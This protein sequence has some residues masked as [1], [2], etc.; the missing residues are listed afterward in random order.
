MTGQG[1]T[2]RPELRLRPEEG[3]LALTMVVVMSLVLAMALDDPAW[4]NGK[5][6]LTDGL[7]WC[8][9]LGTLVGFVGPKVGWGRWTTHLVG[10][11]LAALIIP[12]IAGLAVSPPG[13]SIG[14]AFQEAASGSVQAYLDIAWLGRRFTD[15]EV[16]YILVLGMV[17]WATAQF[18]AYAVFGHGRPLSGVVVSGLVLLGNMALT[19]NNELPYLVVYAGASLLLL[20]EMHVFEERST[21]IRRQIGDPGSI[22]ALYLRGGAVF[23]AVALFGSLMLTDRAA[24]A[25]LA[26][27]WHGLDT[28][29]VDVGRTIQAWL[30]LGGDA[31]SFGSVTFGS[32]AVIGNRWFIGDGIAFTATV[33]STVPK[34]VYWRAASYDSYQ[35]NGWQQASGDTTEVE[36]GQPLLA[37]TPEDPVTELTDPAQVEIRT[38]AYADRT[39]LSPGTP[40]AVSSSA[41]VLL[42]DPGL[43][44]ARVELPGGVT[45][46]TVDA[47]ILRMTDTNVISDHL[48]EAASQDYPQDIVDEYT[49]VPPG[50]IGPNARALLNT[51]LRGAN[52]TNPYD[53]AGA[54]RDF[55]RDPANFQYTTDLRSYPCDDPSAI[56]CFAAT[57]KGF[58][59]Q[60]AST[61]AILLRAA[62][63]GHPIPT[64]YVQGYL[65]GDRTGTTEVVRTRAV[66]AWVE[67]YFPGYGWIPFD[68]TGTVGLA[69]VIQEGPPVAAATPPAAT[70]ATG[71]D[72]GRG[73]LEG[74]PNAIEGSG[75]PFGQTSQ[76]VD[77]LP[78][79]LVTLL[80]LVIV[81]G[82]A[83]GA[84]LRGPRGEVSPDSAWRTLGRAAGR[85]GFAPRPTE[86]VYEYAA[87]LSD[88]VPVA[89]ADLHTVAE[90]KVETTYA[91]ASLGGDRILALRNASRRLRLSLL[92]LLFRRRRRPRRPRLG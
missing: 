28:Q 85:F 61:M 48:L 29:L 59:Q 30:P 82:I 46:Y 67:V 91:R 3:W 14:A 44:L 81:G 18:T 33:P 70:P 83:L 58:C 21:W 27:A 56:E 71:R 15:Q 25:P 42:S 65:P 41:S 23:I 7:I 79:I 37:G 80:L 10:A 49:Q 66:H 73:Q 17:V 39:L 43:S 16:H 51:M 36:A 31:R 2:A 88:L 57:H 78:L 32:S 45:E 34:G 13:T 20:I 74:D 75:T 76:P 84:W 53:L 5:Q 69:S 90:A 62:I 50:A 6:S 11:G 68:P 63:P 24:S 52:T 60:Y 22:G 87:T 47:R 55:L 72:G 9:L 54:F 8:A 35:L 26:G 12:I 89:R 4:V 92:R 86:T 64:R 40:V 77:R 38:D 1:R 19:V